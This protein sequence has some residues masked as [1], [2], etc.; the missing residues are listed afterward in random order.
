[1]ETGNGGLAP[2]MTIESLWKQRKRHIGGYLAA[3]ANRFG[4]ENA[5]LLTLGRRQFLLGGDLV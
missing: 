4:T 1:M 2:R 5:P 3:L